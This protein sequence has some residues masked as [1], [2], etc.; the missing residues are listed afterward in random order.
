M[1]G[2]VRRRRW[3]HI[4]DASLASLRG[5]VPSSTLSLFFAV[6]ISVVPWA[7]LPSSGPQAT[8]LGLPLKILD[9]STKRRRFRNNSTLIYET[10]LLLLGR[11]YC[12]LL[13]PHHYR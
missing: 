4:R 9:L 2:H 11:G 8:P 5:R 13:G 3:G 6:L 7:R 12:G 1:P 10:L